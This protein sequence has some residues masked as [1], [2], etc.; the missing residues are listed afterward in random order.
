LTTLHQLLILLSFLC[1]RLQSV[2]TGVELFFK[3][4]FFVMNFPIKLPSFSVQL[5]I[6]NELYRAPS[7]VTPAFPLSNPPGPNGPCSVASASAV[8]IESRLC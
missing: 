6:E 3:H 5:V 7:R 4:G 1:L 8:S 2:A